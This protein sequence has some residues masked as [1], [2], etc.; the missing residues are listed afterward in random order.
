MVVEPSSHGHQA[1]DVV[2]RR[3]DDPLGPSVDGHDGHVVVGQLHGEPAAL[4]GVQAALD[5]QPRPL[6]AAQV[7][8]V[9]GPQGVLADGQGLREAPGHAGAVDDGHVVGQEVRPRW[10]GGASARC[11]SCRCRSG[12]TASDP[13]PRRPCRRRGG[14]C[15]RGRR[16]RTAAGPRPRWCRGRGGSGPEPGWWSRGSGAPKWMAKLAEA[17]PQLL[18]PPDRSCRQRT[19]PCG[20]APGGDPPCRS[21]WPM[22]GAGAVAD[23]VGLRK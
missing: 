19:A 22:S 5:P 9:D 3:R 21:G 14:A 10:C 20:S 17:A 7:P 16:R 4:L 11:R 18:L 12:P 15:S 6:R 2:L 23:P 1:L 8:G 13:G